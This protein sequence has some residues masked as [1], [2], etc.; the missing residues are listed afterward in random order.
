MLGVSASD[1][2]A[3]GRLRSPSRQQVR[4]RALRDF[5]IARVLEFKEIIAEMVRF[6]KH[7]HKWLPQESEYQPAPSLDFDLRCA[8]HRR[9]HEHQYIAGGS[10]RLGSTSDGRV[11]RTGIASDSQAC[12]PIDLGFGF[13]RRPGE[14][15]VVGM[16]DR[17][18]LFPC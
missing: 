6:V 17:A 8:W 3:V 16:Y 5:K 14:P 12:T 13:E 11:K 4:E 18:K 9:S 2:G 10:Q 15:E 7:E 1:D